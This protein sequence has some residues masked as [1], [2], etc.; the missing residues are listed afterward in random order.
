ML[1][2][3]LGSDS[4]YS[5]LI[6]SVYC[7]FD[8]GSGSFDILYSYMDV[9][10]EIPNTSQGCGEIFGAPLVGIGLGYLKI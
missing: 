4:E 10:A 1:K 2:E 5:P 6:H 9:P 7:L 3:V 8:M